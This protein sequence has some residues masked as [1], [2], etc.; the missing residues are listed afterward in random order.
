MDR[1]HKAHGRVAKDIYAN[2]WCAMPGSGYAEISCI[3]QI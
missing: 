2:R 1:E 3:K